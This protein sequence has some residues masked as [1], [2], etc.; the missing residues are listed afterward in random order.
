MGVNL[1]NRSLLELSLRTFDVD[2][3]GITGIG[4][5]PRQLPGR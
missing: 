4:S 2:N 5:I 3:A 1:K